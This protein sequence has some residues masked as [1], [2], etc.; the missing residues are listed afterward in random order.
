VLLANQ[1]PDL[2]IRIGRIAHAQ[3]VGALGEALDETLA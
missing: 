1:R 2:G 3:A